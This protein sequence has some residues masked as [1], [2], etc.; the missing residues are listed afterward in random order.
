MGG[1]TVGRVFADWATGG[2]WEIGHAAVDG[3]DDYENLE[4]WK[5]IHKSL[6]ENK[7][8]IQRELVSNNVPPARLKSIPTENRCIVSQFG[9]DTCDL[10]IQCPIPDILDI[11]HAGAYNVIGG[12]F[13]RSDLV[14][15]CDGTPPIDLCAPPYQLA[16]CTG[17]TDQSMCQAVETC[18]WLDSPSVG[19][20]CRGTC[21][22]PPE[23]E[24][25]T[26]IRDRD[27]CHSATIDDINAKYVTGFR[28]CNQV[29]PNEDD[30]VA[31]PYC[32]WNPKYNSCTPRQMCGWTPEGVC[33]PYDVSIALLPNVVREAASAGLKS[34]SARA[35]ECEKD[36]KDPGRKTIAALPNCDSIEMCD[37]VCNECIQTCVKDGKLDNSNLACLSHQVNGTLKMCA[38][39]C[40]SCM[41]YVK[42]PLD[43]EEYKQYEAAKPLI[44]E[45]KNKSPIRCPADCT[46]LRVPNFDDPN[47]IAYCPQRAVSDQSGAVN[48]K[49]DAICKT[50]ELEAQCNQ[51]AGCIWDS[52]TSSCRASVC[53][54]KCPQ[55]ENSCESLGLGENCCSLL[56]NC[57]VYEDACS[58][59]KDETNCTNK[60]A[61][62]LQEKC[63][64]KT[65]QTDCSD[66]GCAWNASASTCTMCAGLDPE[67]CM[68]Q[69]ACSLQGGDWKGDPCQPFELICQ[70]NDDIAS[71]ASRPSLR[72]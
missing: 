27:E 64:K 5:E 60:T 49:T 67:Q 31:I 3:I 13:G 52:K 29:K 7:N 55:Y 58:A 63:S 43:S 21:V 16:D 41:D 10:C 32:T 8:T 40:G 66:V 25:C 34:T 57:S 30:C 19:P 4:G 46:E 47:S 36:I 48:P 18:E 44:E 56:S 17:I 61:E 6:L 20:Q 59:I 39:H 50:F 38:Q 45:L 72:Q 69:S 9:G 65:T 11:S 15:I 24:A 53:C 37:S 14:H 35:G 51:G 42:L 33:E 12:L 28:T 68:N 71:C 22:I 26:D 23:Y 70:W 54:L 1:S 2:I 62:G